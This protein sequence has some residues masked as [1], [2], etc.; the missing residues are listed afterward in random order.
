HAQVKLLRVLQEGEVVRLGSAKPTK[1]DVRIISATNRVLTEEMGSGRFREDIFYRLSVALLKIPPLRERPG[2][3]GLLID[4]LL[5][6]VNKLAATEPG[7]RD[8][9]LSAGA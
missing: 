5:K 8:K 6:D 1:I 2:D 9:T 4:R 3:L 7:Y